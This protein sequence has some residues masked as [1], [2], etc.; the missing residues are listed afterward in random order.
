[1]VVQA[2]AVVKQ[3]PNSSQVYSLIFTEQ[4]VKSEK[5]K[6]SNCWSSKKDAQKEG[7]QWFSYERCISRC[8]AAQGSSH[9]MKESSETAPTSHLVRI[10]ARLL[11]FRLWEEWAVGHLNGGEGARSN[12]PKKLEPTFPT[13]RSFMACLFYLRTSS[14]LGFTK[15]VYCAPHHQLTDQCW[16]GQALL[17]F[18]SAQTSFEVVYFSVKPQSF[19]VQL[20]PS[21]TFIEPFQDPIRDPR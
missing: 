20:R 10:L 4:L 17:P 5:A 12:W 1:M 21:H 6:Q 15:V 14:R 3:V 18:S 7:A 8:V 19:F 2:R 9:R 16:F 13:R 11:P